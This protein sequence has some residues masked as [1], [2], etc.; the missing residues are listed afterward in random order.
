[1][2]TGLGLGFIKTLMTTNTRNPVVAGNGGEEPRSRTQIGAGAIPMTTEG[3]PISSTQSLT[4]P[5]RLY[6]ETLKQFG[7]SKLSTKSSLATATETGCPT[8]MS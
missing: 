1:M 3:P 8:F 5:T 6:G 4:G 7:P 2:E